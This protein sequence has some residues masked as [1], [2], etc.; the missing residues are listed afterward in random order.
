VV[1]QVAA[2]LGVF[3][4]IVFAFL[5]VRGFYAPIQTRRLVRRFSPSK[6]ASTRAPTVAPLD[7]HEQEFLTTHAAAV[8]AA[9]VGWFACA[10]FASVAYHWIFYYILAMATTPRDY[11]LTRAAAH[12][13]PS[14]PAS[15]P[16]V[17]VGAHA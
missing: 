1:L 14:R 4:L 3:G 7:R 13:H 11:L 2:E 6:R 5:L 8:T 9:L 16:V 15:A 17:A 10:L 12:R